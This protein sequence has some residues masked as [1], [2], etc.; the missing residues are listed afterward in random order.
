M[1]IGALRNATVI[2]RIIEMREQLDVHSAQLATGKISESFAG[3]GGA[4]GTSL[5]VRSK[6]SLIEGYNQSIGQVSLRARI[7]N[8][9]LDRMSNIITE[10]RSLNIDPSFVPVDGQQSMQQKNAAQF[11]QEVVGLL[12]QDVGGRK[13]FS[14]RA[15]N[16]DASLSADAI[17][18]GSNGRQGLRDVITERRTA[19]GVGASGR[20]DVGLVGTT[21]SLSKQIVGAPPAAVSDQLGFSIRAAVSS[22]AA[23]TAT[24]LAG[25]PGS[26]TLAVNTQ[27]TVGDS[28]L[29]T[30]GLPDGRTFDM[31]FEAATTATNDQTFAIGATT[32]A[33]AAN[34]QAAVSAEL[35]KRANSDLFSASAI[36]ASE[37]FFDI[38]AGKAPLRV[39]ADGNALVQDSTNTLRWYTGD[40]ALG[41]PRATAT[42]RIDS[43][44]T[45]GYGMRANEEGFRKLLSGLGAFA[46][47]NFNPASA[48]TK[49]SYAALSLDVRDFLGKTGGQT[50]R[51]IQSEVVV[52]ENAA[53]ATK[54]RHTATS[55]ILNDVL[56]EAEDIPKEEVATKILALQTN[57]QASYQVTAMVSQ[58]SLVNY[59]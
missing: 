6:L 14:G 57:L 1:T 11:L 40:D 39:N 26:A 29:L 51:T 18:N 48:T 43:A 56:G 49:E 21:V 30:I 36:A 23:I 19:D 10:Q 13:L 15:T 52:I 27:P 25:P 37:G 58:M 22:S 24:A 46:A 50:I 20:V 34:L 12:N 45:V 28:V 4:R 41:D 38:D 35:G 8:N 55:S 17:L 47:V 44:V 7:A 33:T 16:T 54:E 3:L 59:L 42:A 2:R 31:R 53:Q 32:A 9:S 5:D